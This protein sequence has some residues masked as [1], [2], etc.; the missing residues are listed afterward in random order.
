MSGLTHQSAQAPPVLTGTY[1]GQ[2]LS[3]PMT[4][5]TAA[6]PNGGL[7]TP[8]P[9]GPRFNAFILLP[10]GS[11]TMAAE[12]LSLL[13]QLKIFA[14]GA[15][16]VVS[17]DTNGGPYQLETAM[18]CTGSSEWIQVPQ[19]PSVVGDGHAVTLPVRSAQQL[20]RLKRLSL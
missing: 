17:W 6:T 5:L 16:V 12:E 10:L 7:P 14:A 18:G 3:L 15:N 8:A 9:T 19:A 4:N 2:L 20:Y 11:M 13:P 1:T